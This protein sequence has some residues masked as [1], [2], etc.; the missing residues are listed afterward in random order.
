MP[1]T[2]TGLWKQRLR[3]AEGGVQMMV[4]FFWRMVRC[5][6]PSLLPTYINYLSCGLML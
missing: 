2:L 1:E 5:T 4:D 3:W 6:S